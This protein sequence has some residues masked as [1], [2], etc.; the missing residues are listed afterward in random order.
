MGN[1]ASA[2]QSGPLKR[3]RDAEPGEETNTSDYFFAK[4]LTS[5]DLLSL[6]VCQFVLGVTNAQLTVLHLDRG[7]AFPASSSL[8]SS[9]PPQPP[10]V[11][12]KV[13]KGNMGNT[14]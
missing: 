8:S 10:L 14:T 11:V 6:E 4:F 5:A 3:K 9:H 2:I 12:Y 1:R 7:H 13:G